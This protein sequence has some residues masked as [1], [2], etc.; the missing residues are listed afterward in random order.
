ML[1]SAGADPNIRNK[2]N[3]IA[4][5]LAV[6]TNN[7]EAVALLDYY[8]NRMGPV[9]LMAATQNGDLIKVKELLAAGANPFEKNTNNQ[10]R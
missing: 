4:R 7:K 6:R 5:E 10:L 8:S 2:E 3:L 9:S 1:L